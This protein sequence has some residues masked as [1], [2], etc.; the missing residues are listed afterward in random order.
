MLGVRDV[1]APALVGPVTLPGGQPQHLACY[2]LLVDANGVL[3]AGVFGGRQKPLET[4]EGQFEL[5]VALAV[6]RPRDQALAFKL[7]AGAAYSLLDAESPDK[8]GILRLA[9]HKSLIVG[10]ELERLGDDRHFYV[11]G[12]WD[13]PAPDLEVWAERMQDILELPIVPEWHGQLWAQVLARGWA[14]PCPVARGWAPCWSVTTSQQEWLD[15]V[16]ELT[17]AGKLR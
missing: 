10:E 3:V 4:L 14:A 15:L 2:G 11:F 13:S 16:L 12:G 5:G 1:L 6:Q 8:Q 9:L 7:E 17:Q